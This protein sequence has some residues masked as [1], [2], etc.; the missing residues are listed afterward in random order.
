MFSVTENHLAIILGE[1]SYPALQQLALGADECGVHAKQEVQRRVLQLL[2]PE[3][4][5]AA[6]FLAALAQCHGVLTGQ[7][8]VALLDPLGAET[9]QAIDVVVGS[10][11][12]TRFLWLLSLDEIEGAFIRRV[13]P[14]G[15]P[16]LQADAFIHAVEM[17]GEHTTFRVVQSPSTSALFSIPYFYST[18][19]MNYVTN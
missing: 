4:K 5:N 6:L 10:E 19:L 17:G 11:D 2:V 13:L 1:L 3:V 7:F 18:H 8:V 14:T 15:I 16:G 12:Y 9:F